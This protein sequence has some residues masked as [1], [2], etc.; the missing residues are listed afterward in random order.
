MKTN[1]YDGLDTPLKIRL[2]RT[3]FRAPQS[4]EKHKD[5]TWKDLPHGFRSWVL[6]TKDALLKEYA[7]GLN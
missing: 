5:K 1:G 3:Y 4:V 2:L 6:I 7:E